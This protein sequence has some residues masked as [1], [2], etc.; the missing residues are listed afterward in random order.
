MCTVIVVTPIKTVCSVTV[1]TP[2]KTVCSV[3]VMT[4]MKTVCSVT[5][6]TPMKTT[7]VLF[8]CRELEREVNVGWT[9]IVPESEADGSLLAL[10]LYRSGF[11]LIRRYG[12]FYCFGRN[13]FKN[14]NEDIFMR[15]LSIENETFKSF[16][17]LPFLILL[18]Y[19][20]FLMC[21]DFTVIFYG[22][23]SLHNGA[24]EGNGHEC[25]TYFNFLI[26]YVLGKET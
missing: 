24:F 17:N 23:T 11:I 9:D 25:C 20:L 15:E 14:L 1:V 16:K 6:M 22:L 21:G 10:M 8:V 18:K 26:C 7:C 4:P 12:C 2:M 19:R 5:V 3:T 13:F